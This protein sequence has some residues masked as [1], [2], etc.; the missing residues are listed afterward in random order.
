MRPMTTAG[1][2]TPPARGRV[3][4]V[5][6]EPAVCLALELALRRAGYQVVAVHSGDAAEARLRAEPFD[7]LVVDLRMPDVR[8]D[9]VY[10]QA[11]ALQPHLRTR[12]LF[13]TGDVTGR[14]QRT[15]EACGCPLVRK[16]FD[17][18][19]LLDGLHAL[20]PAASAMEE[21]A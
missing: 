1:A 18:R 15:I 11:V 21:S 3:L 9:V 4:V 19:D 5:D 16:P 20:L 12:T 6:A 14:A 8:G 13:V 17:L 10:H 7:A 2:P